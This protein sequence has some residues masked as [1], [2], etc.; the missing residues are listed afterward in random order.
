MQKETLRER[1]R[2]VPEEKVE[3]LLNRDR[4]ES[5]ISY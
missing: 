4:E 3:Q 2:E 1:E 5:G